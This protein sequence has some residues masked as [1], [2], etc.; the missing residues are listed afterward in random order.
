MMGL[1]GII[2][3]IVLILTKG[4]AVKIPYAR[5]TTLSGFLY[6]KRNF[7]VEE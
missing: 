2:G 4:S 6:V 5:I 3:L 7:G 1:S